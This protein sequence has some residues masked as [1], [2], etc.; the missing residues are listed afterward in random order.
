[1]RPKVR[2]FS[3]KTQGLGLSGDNGRDIATATGGRLFNGNPVIKGN[4]VNKGL[5]ALLSK[6]A[7]LFFTAAEHDLDFDLVTVLKEGFGTVYTDI[8]VILTH[9]DRETDA[10]DV[11]F[12]GMGLLGAHFFL[13]MILKLA[14]IEDFTDR[15][16]LLR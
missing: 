9:F 10:F 15:R 7:M 3:E 13:F 12:L 4:L 8:K 5:N 14:I 2:L 1:M 6:V 16:I 11:N